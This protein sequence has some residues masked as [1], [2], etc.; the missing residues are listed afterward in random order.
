MEYT[1][2]QKI[3]LEGCTIK[4][5]H[6]INQ[7][8]TDKSDGRIKIFLSWTKTE[9]NDRIFL[10]TYWGWDKKV[11]VMKHISVIGQYAVSVS[12]NKDPYFA[13]VQGNNIYYAKF[14]AASVRK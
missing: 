13:L 14:A 11:T 10:G 9:N 8:T 1:F 12:P 6:I 7:N 2:F 4:T 5:F 3:P